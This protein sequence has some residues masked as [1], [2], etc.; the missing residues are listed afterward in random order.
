VRRIIREY[1]LE[2]IALV[3]AATGVLLV[4][5]E[6]SIR[7]VLSLFIH[8]TVAHLGSWAQNFI[9]HFSINDLL[10]GVLVLAGLSFII[11][12]G[13][14]HFYQSEYWQAV[15]CPKC[16]SDLRRIHRTTWD[17]FLSRTLL[18]DARRYRCKNP[19]CGWSGLRE[20]RDEDRHHHRHDP[21][22]VD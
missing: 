14:Y 16:G 9:A 20:K 4:V 5:K 15:N 7:E 12:R 2:F 10:G 21:T 3:I 6:I 18:R 17:R 11:W 19:A 8:N 13:Q 22:E 1:W